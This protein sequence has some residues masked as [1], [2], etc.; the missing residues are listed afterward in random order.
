MALLVS[1]E[2]ISSSGK[3]TAIQGIK[4]RLKRRGFKVEV[5]DTDST[6]DAPLL[7]P[8]ARMYPVEHPA[9]TL[10]YWVL[11]LQQHDAA[12]MAT[13]A[14]V[15]L[16]DRFWISTYVFDVCLNDVPQEVWDWVTRYI[17]FYPDITLFFEVSEYVAR[18]RREPKVMADRDLSRIVIESYAKLA[19]ENSWVC[20]NAEQDVDSVVTNCLQV[21]N[22]RL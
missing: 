21:I 12:G 8:I 20:I 10:L 15:V 13:D 11:R 22:P 17:T 5:V 1:F 14:D 16:A 3:T 7:H 18:K 9:R 6:G 4:R 19:K 2:G